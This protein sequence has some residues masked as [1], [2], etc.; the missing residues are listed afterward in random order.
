MPKLKVLHVLGAGMNLLK[1]IVLMGASKWRGLLSSVIATC[2]F[3]GSQ[4][5]SKNQF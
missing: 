3:Q 4:K 2:A 1:G 5:A